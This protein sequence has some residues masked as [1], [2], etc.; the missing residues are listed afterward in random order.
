MF[1]IGMVRLG[2]QFREEALRTTTSYHE[3]DLCTGTTNE[4]QSSRQCR[5]AGYSRIVE[6]EAWSGGN[7]ES[8]LTTIPATNKFA[9]LFKKE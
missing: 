7:T 5:Q 2:R 4:N 6:L 8:E 9:F 3:T 1:N